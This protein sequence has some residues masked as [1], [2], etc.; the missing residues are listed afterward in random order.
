MGKQEQLYFESEMDEHPLRPDSEAPAQIVGSTNLYENGQL[1]Y[2]PMPTPDPKDPLNL[3][4]WRKIAALMSVCFFGALALSS[5][6]IIGA[7]IPVFA[8]EY[9]GIDPK[10]LAKV[11][12]SA[13]SPPGSVNLNP[14]KLLAG[15]GGPPL[16]KTSLLA[17]LPLLTNGISSYFLVPLS[18][19]IGRRP[20]L[21]ACGIMAWS[22]GF[23]AAAS[24]SLYSHLAARCIQAVG[25]GAVEA[26]VPL[27]VQDLV[28]IHQRNR[29]MSFVWATQG[30]I[31]VTLGIA[32][33]IIVAD[34]GWRYLYI[35]TSGLAVFA[36]LALVAFLPE[37][38]WERSAEELS[39]KNV[40]YLFPGEG[41]PRVDA[42]T[43]GS[44]TLWTNLGLFQNGFEHRA[45]IQSMIDTLR[46]MCFPNIIWVIAVNGI[47]FAV[48]GAAGQTGSSVL[49]ASGWKFRNLGLAVLPIVLA[50]PFVALLGG[51]LADRVT[52]AVAKRNGGRREPE[53]NLLNIVLPLILGIAGCVLFGYAGENLKTVHWSVLLTGIFSICLG[54][55]TTNTVLIVYVIESYPKWAGPVLVNISSW[56]CII[57]FALS[58]RATDW[59]EE[60]GFLGSFSIYAGIL[61]ALACIL[62]V[63]YVCG[64][65][66]RQW[67]AGTVKSE[68]SPSGKDGSH[69]EG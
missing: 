2:I 20:V 33:P 6:T 69:L 68:K 12:I 40:Y 44:R 65:R 31:I 41:R 11:D 13:L 51:Y 9:A 59:V 64:K 57:G 7:L 25:A 19:S 39:G 5:E 60:R 49:I 30:L 53:G 54:F 35:L 38:R 21:L 16:W 45:A 55:L 36:W 4:Q 34:I 27:I 48:Q 23:W 17:S 28:F 58:F 47:F 63:M 42:L 24:R 1:N 8:L 32:S 62:P 18:I 37:T 46:T 26:L 15:L 43:H 3:P 56:R 29:A 14:L 10:I 61:A 22:G 67:T 52:N 50:T 66:I